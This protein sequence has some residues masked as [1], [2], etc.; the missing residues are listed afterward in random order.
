M[1]HGRDDGPGHD[2]ELTMDPSHSQHSGTF[3]VMMLQSAALLTLGCTIPYATTQPPGSARS[4][5]YPAYALG[6]DKRL[7]LGI[8]YR[9]RPPSILAEPL[10]PATLHSLFPFASSTGGSGSKELVMCG[11]EYC[12]LSPF[13]FPSMRFPCCPGWICCAIR[14]M[15]SN[16]LPHASWT[17]LL[18][19]SALWQSIA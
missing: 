7:F 10:R 18:P 8:A 15:L 2:A 9:R 6:K 17:S 1:I 4:A 3:P 19:H 12:R 11:Q 16:K 14:F 13:S 5:F